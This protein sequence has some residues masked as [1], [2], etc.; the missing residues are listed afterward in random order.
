MAFLKGKAA[1][2]SLV[3]QI[4]REYKVDVGSLRSGFVIDHEGKPLIVLNKTHG[5][6]GRGPAVIK[7]D[8]KNAL[9]GQKIQQRFKSG[10]TVEVIQLIQK[11]YQLL[12]VADKKAHLMNME[13]FEELELPADAIEGGESKLPFAVDGMDVIVQSLEPEPGPISWRLPNR[14]SYVVESVEE[15]RAQAKGTTYCPAMISGGGMVQVPSFVK[16]GESIIV[17][18]QEERYVSRTT[19]NDE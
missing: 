16:P 17:D 9:T 11:D 6:T 14:Y 19:G 3:H 5:G 13:T 2:S 10:S 12:Y 1:S 18:T 4:T 7:V 15:R 8:F